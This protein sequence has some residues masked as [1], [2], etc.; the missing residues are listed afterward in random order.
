MQHIYI[1]I[2]HNYIGNRKKI[3]LRMEKNTVFYKINKRETDR[4]R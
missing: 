1:E 3:H 4:N 2:Q